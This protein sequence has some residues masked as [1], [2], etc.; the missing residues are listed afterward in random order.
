QQV[1][2]AIGPQLQK[3]SLVVGVGAQV[4]GP[5]HAAAIGRDAGHK[6]IDIALRRGQQCPRRGGKIGAERAARHVHIAA[7]IELERVGRIG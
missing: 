7:G 6:A 5:L 1:H 3:I 4:G 2:P